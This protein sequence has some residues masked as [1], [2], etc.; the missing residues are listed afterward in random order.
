VNPPDVPPLAHDAPTPGATLLDRV[1]P[2]TRLGAAMVLTVPLFI[3]LD[4]VSA[5]ATAGAEII[6]WLALHRR[7]LAADLRALS[8]RLIPFLVA[9][10]LA[11]VSMSLYGNPG[12]NSYWSWGLIHISDQSLSFGA[13]VAARVVAL[14]TAVIVTLAFVDPTDMADGLAQVW[15]LPARFVLGTLAG[16]RLIATMMADWRSMELARRARGLGDHRA[17]RRFAGLAFALLVTAIRK[18]STLATAMEVR[19]FGRGPRTWARQSKVGIPDVVCIAA[20][21][22]IVGLGLMLSLVTGHFRW[23]GSVL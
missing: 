3:S 5:A 6:V 23:I 18:G 10:P 11:G 7:S 20:A 21:T 9:A 2:V 1:N 17:L 13:A 15:H 19:G 8:L 12:G 22:M 16:V 4:W 14:G